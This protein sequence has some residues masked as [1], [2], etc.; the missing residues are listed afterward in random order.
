MG[1][2]PGMPHMAGAAGVPMPGMA[3]P[4]GLPPGLG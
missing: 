3:P 2:Q 4:P 1:S